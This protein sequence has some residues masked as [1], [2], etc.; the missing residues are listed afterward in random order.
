MESSLI[1][2][3]GA[4]VLGGGAAAL[5]WKPLIAGIASIVTSNRAGGEIITSYKEQVLLLKESNALLRQENDDLRVRHDTNLRRIST[6]ETDLRLIKNA[7]GILV[8]MTDADQNSKFRNEID[9][10][11]S[12][13]EDRNDGRDTQ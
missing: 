10:L 9:R 1:T 2:S 7:L 5:F 13:L 3:V 4:L 6:L 8:A 11:I 12:T